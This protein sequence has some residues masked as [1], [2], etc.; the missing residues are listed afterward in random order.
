MFWNGVRVI[1]M[2]ASLEARVPL[3]GGAATI[4]QL[5][6]DDSASPPLL[7]VVIGERI[8]TWELKLFFWRPSEARFEGWVEKGVFS[9]DGSELVAISPIGVTYLWKVPSGGALVEFES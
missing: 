5:F 4:S 3:P 2:E 7:H 1:E 6:F 9:A 8:E